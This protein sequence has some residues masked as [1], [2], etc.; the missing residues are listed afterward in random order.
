MLKIPVITSILLLLTLFNSCSTKNKI[1][2]MIKV[3][4]GSFQMG[5]QTV[6]VSSFS[7]SKYVIMQGEWNAIMRKNP[8]K[9]KTDLNYPVSNVSWYDTILYCNRRS[10]KEG[11]TPVYSIGGSTDPGAWGK[12]F[13]KFDAVNGS[14]NFTWDTVKADWSANGYRLPTEMEWMWAAMGGDTANPGHTNTTGYNKAFAGST[15]ENKIGEYAWTHENNGGI[16]HPVGMKLANELGLYDMNGNVYQFCW[17]WYADD[18]PSGSLTDY[19]GAASGNYRVIRGGYWD[20]DASCATI[21][22][23]NYFSSFYRS[24]DFGFRVVRQ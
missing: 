13:P 24:K 5:S 19:R 14:E 22:I 20:N 1:N 6:T 10:I 12:E 21:A 4:G 8:S 16:V 17:D 18:F 7:I 3:N 2:E 9:N 11:L 23:R 15:G